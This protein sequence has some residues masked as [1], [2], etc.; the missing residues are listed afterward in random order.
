MTSAATTT[1]TIV[2][3]RE[4]T[5]DNPHNS[6]GSNYALIPVLT[7]AFLN[8]GF[9]Y[10]AAEN[11]TISNVGARIVQAAGD[12][13]LRFERTATNG[14]WNIQ[15]NANNDLL[16]KEDT[17]TPFTFGGGTSEDSM[18]TITEEEASG[19][20]ILKLETANVSNTNGD[21]VLK[22]ATADGTNWAIGYDRSEGF[23]KIANASELGSSDIALFGTGLSHFLINEIRF[24]DAAGTGSA[25]LRIGDTGDPTIRKGA[26]APSDRDWET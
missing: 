9:G 13:R 10:D 22:F 21:A 11:E 17:R 14:I 5:G 19:D 7:A 18:L 16:F 2:R 24:R 8:N 1:L 25:I 23:F 6:G 3:D 20:A 4:S 12:P 26:N 15:V